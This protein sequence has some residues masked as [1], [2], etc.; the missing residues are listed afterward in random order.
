MAAATRHFTVKEFMD[1]PRPAG[2]MRQE[3]HHGELLE[4]PPVKHGHTKTQRRLGSALAASLDSRFLADKEIAFQPLPE[5]EA[6]VADVAVMD[7]ARWEST[8]ENGYFVGV[9]EI[10]IEVLSPS[11]TASEMLDRERMCLTNGGREFWQVDQDRQTVKITK[12]DGHSRSYGI[13][14]TIAMTGF[15][16]PLRVA[17]LFGI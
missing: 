2:G 15:G 13:Q 16:R 10:V 3:L 11:N 7:V 12:A 17:V 4:M 1:L 5:H 6:W 14:E 9:P 8:P